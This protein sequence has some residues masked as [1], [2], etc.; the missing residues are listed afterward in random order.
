MFVLWF[1]VLFFLHLLHLLLASSVLSSGHLLPFTLGPVI[2][3]ATL[4]LSSFQINCPAVQGDF[5][6]LQW[7]APDI[8]RQ[9]DSTLLY[10]FDRWRGLNQPILGAK[11]LQLAG[12]PFNAEAGSFSFL[13]QPGLRDGGVYTCNVFL[14]DN[15]YSQKT[16]I[17]VFKGTF[18]W[19]KV[20]MKQKIDR[21]E[22]RYI[23]RHIYFLITIIIN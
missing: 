12:T 20:S 18:A 5:V 10:H 13:L 15:M 14:N 8:R 11:K 6:R 7:Q 17:T 9:R 21:I 19:E 16:F 23:N 3:S 1:F 4:A 22:N 2:A